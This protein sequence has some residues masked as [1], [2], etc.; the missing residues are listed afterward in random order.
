LPED[1]EEIR[2]LQTTRIKKTIENF[3]CNYCLKKYKT[4]ASVKMH[5]QKDRVCRAIHKVKKFKPVKEDQDR[6]MAYKFV[7]KPCNKGMPTQGAYDK[8]IS[9]YHQDNN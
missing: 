7:C 3:T 1:P 9:R 5:L 8:H 6:N 2:N 4:R